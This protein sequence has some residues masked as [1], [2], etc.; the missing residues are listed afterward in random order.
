MR[1]GDSRESS[2]FSS[3]KCRGWLPHCG[4]GVVT[5]GTRRKVHEASLFV[6]EWQ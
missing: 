6:S 4:G 3:E 5:D 1:A 2:A